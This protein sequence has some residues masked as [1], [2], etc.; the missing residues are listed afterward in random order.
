MYRV[1]I[2]IEFKMKCNKICYKCMLYAAPGSYRGLVEAGL[3]GPLRP[4][5]LLPLLRPFPP[6]QSHVM[7]TRYRRV[8]QFNK[9]SFDKFGE[10]R[11]VRLT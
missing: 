6:A 7:L 5:A 3:H 8:S 11:S 1:H 4:A 10:R 2:L 9:S